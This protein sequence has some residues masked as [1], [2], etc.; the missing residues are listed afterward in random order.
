MPTVARTKCAAR[1]APRAQRVR[2]FARGVHAHEPWDRPTH[3]SS[4]EQ[5]AIQLRMALKRAAIKEGLLDA[6][7]A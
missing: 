1:Q 2:A 7:D 4:Q 6:A 3:E 5:L